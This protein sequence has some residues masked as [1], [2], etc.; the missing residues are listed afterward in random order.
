[1]ADKCLV[2]QPLCHSC[3]Q[4]LVLPRMRAFIC[5]KLCTIEFS[6]ICNQV[7]VLLPQ[8]NSF[9]NCESALSDE[10]HESCN[11]GLQ[12][13]LLLLPHII[14]LYINHITLF[15]ICKGFCLRF[16]SCLWWIHILHVFTSS[17]DFGWDVWYLYSASEDMCNRQSECTFCYT[18]LSTWP[19]FMPLTSIRICS[20][21]LLEIN[22]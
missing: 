6:I 22:N 1:M 11:S 20:L 8:R 9:I 21:L 10:R 2:T 16:H 15:F 12:V 13:V 5:C 14:F 19:W 7:L 18:L 4:R 3:Y 17:C